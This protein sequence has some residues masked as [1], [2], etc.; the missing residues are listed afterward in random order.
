MRNKDIVERLLEK[1]P[2]LGFEDHDPTYED[3]Q[4]AA[5]EIKRL[6]DIIAKKEQGE[7]ENATPLRRKSYKSP[8][9]G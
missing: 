3:R 6:R 1:P 2:S 7:K 4:E 5:K 8:V 9:N